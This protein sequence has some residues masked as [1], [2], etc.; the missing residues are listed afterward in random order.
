MD[1][2]GV[3]LESWGQYDQNTLYVYMKELIKYI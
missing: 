3:G 2:G 1:L